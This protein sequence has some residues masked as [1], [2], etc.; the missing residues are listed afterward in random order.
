MHQ[1]VAVGNGRPVH[2]GAGKFG[3]LPGL[4]T[5]ARK[6]ECLPRLH[7]EGQ[8]RREVVFEADEPGRRLARAVAIRIRMHIG[9]V[10]ATIIRPRREGAIGSAPQVARVGQ[11]SNRG[12]V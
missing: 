12:I 6:G 10:P 2:Q 9:N 1:H 5:R 11:V 8:H 7:V 3:D 4:E